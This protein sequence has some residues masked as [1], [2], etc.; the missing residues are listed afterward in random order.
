MRAKGGQ[1]ILAEGKKIDRDAVVSKAMR[2]Y[3]RIFKDM[4]ADKRFLAEQIYPTAAY[5][6]GVVYELKEQ[7]AEV[8]FIAEQVNGNGFARVDTTPAY[9]E[10][11]DTAIKLN[12]CIDTLG[13]LCPE[14]KKAL[15]NCREDEFISYISK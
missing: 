9:K 11:K 4:P 2:G 15:G 1:F 12:S 5:L 13:K 8:G 10:L 14:L 7:V 3:K 6:A